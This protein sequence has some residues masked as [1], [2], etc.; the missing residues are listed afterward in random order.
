MIEIGS[1]DVAVW[2]NHV[3]ARVGAGRNVIQSAHDTK[4]PVVTYPPFPAKANLGAEAVVG[5]DVGVVVMQTD[6]ARPH[7]QAQKQVV[8]EVPGQTQTAQGGAELVVATGT[9]CVTV[10]RGIGIICRSH[11][12]QVQRQDQ[13]AGNGITEAEIHIRGAATDIHVASGAGEVVMASRWGHTDIEVK[14]LMHRRSTRSYG[15]C[16]GLQGHHQRGNNCKNPC[17]NN[18]DLFHFP[19]PKIEHAPLR[20][21][22]TLKNPVCT[23]IASALSNSVS[24]V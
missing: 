15:T 14:P 7:S 18:K 24:V 3:N 6:L 11:A 22:G 10:Q 20:A 2:I 1:V 17:D 8:V 9:E 23:E 16:V 12:T 5:I 21:D 19:P 13:V 4:P